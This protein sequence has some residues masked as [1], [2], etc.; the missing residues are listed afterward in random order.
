MFKRHSPLATEPLIGR[1]GANG[2]RRY[3]FTLAPFGEC[4]LLASYRGQQAAFTREL[5]TLLGIE[6]RH[7]PSSEQRFPQCTLLQVAP[8]QFWYLTS[9][10]TLARHLTDHHF[11]SGSA[12]PLSHSRVRVVIT[13]TGIHELLA[14]GISVDLDPTIFRVGQFMQTALEHI[15]ILLH[16]RADQQYELYLPATFAR[17]LWTWLLDAA[18]EEG[19]QL[20]AE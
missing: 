1:D 3:R 4:V 13:G 20:E 15:G 5:A 18:L 10:Q 14:K 19:Y 9:D 17:T 2:L 7:S 8:T 12:T 6:P 11:T 16:R